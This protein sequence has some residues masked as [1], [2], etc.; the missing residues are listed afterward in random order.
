MLSRALLLAGAAAT[1]LAAFL[2]WVTVKGLTIS[3][4]LGLV[5]ADVGAANRTVL[6]TDTALWPALVGAGAVVAV[7]A[8]L[9]IARA[10]LLVLGVLVTAAGGLLLIYMANVIDVE[11]RGD[12]AMERVLAGTV[13]SS[14]VGPGTPLLLAGGLA[15][16]AGAALRRGHGD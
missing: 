15:I 14:S 9:G 12:S 4:D 2:P 1:V 6:G 13:L 3:L 10:L 8:L 16:I 5:G 7:L 11:T